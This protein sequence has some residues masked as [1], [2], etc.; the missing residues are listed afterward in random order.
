MKNKNININIKKSFYLILVN[1]HYEITLLVND[2]HYYIHNDYT[3][4]VIT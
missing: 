1:Y 3:V 2:S 4:I